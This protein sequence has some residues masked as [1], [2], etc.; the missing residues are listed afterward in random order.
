M[1]SLFLAL[2]HSFSIIFYRIYQ[3]LDNQIDKFVHDI[4]SLDPEKEDIQ[5]DAIK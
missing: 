4:F 1:I 5:I 2:F 3:E